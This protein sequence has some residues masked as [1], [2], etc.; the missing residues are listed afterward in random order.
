MH[1]IQLTK[2]LIQVNYTSCLF[3][4]THKQGGEY[5]HNTFG[6]FPGVLHYLEPR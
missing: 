2:V 1:A 4:V 6:F 5:S 3:K